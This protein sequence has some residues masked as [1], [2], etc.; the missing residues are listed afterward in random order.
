MVDELTAA[1]QEAPG[2]CG[3]FELDSIPGGAVYARAL[4]ER[5][6]LLH[7]AARNEGVTRKLLDE[8]ADPEATKGDGTRPLHAA[9]E[10]ATATHHGPALA[11]GPWRSPRRW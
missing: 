4:T 8:G 6:T 1:L 11:T 3:P 9:V 5:T 7:A 10:A 2:F